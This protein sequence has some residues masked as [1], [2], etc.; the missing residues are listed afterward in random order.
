MFHKTETLNKTKEEYEKKNEAM[1]TAANTCRELQNR[2]REEIRKQD[3]KTN[4]MKIQ[5]PVKVCV[6][7]FKSFAK[8]STNGQKAST[9]TVGGT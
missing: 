1:N 6:P 9:V 5:F 7:Q 2:L 4:A 3:A 8:D